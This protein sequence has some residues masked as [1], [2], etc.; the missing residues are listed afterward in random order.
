M[1]SRLAGAILTVREA[2]AS[3]LECPVE[4]VPPDD[5][6][7][8]D[9][10]LDELECESLGLIL[11]EVF[12]ITVPDELWK[13]CLYRTPTSLAEWCIRTSDNAAW[14]SCRQQ[15]RA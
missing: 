4:S 12:G 1:N 8:D 9:A 5:D 11:E 2:V 15:R 14:V 7:I 10:C 13:S 3:V 6:L